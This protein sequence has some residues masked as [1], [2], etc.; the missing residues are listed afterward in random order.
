MENLLASTEIGTIFLDRDLCIRKF[1]PQIAEQFHLLPQDIGRSINSF[2]HTIVHP[3]LLEDLAHVLSSGQRR[4]VEVQDRQGR[5][6]YLRI[7]PYRVK[8]RMEGVVL[9]LIDI[10]TIKQVQAELAQAVR[11]RDQFLAMLSHELRNPLGAILNAAN[12]LERCPN[13]GAL[14]TELGDIICRQSQHMARLLDDLLDVSR[15]T[16]NKIEMR[17][18]PVAISTIIQGAVEAVRP[19]IEQNKLTFHQQSSPVDLAVLGDPVRLQQAVSNLLMNSAKYTPSGG[20]IRLETMD[21]NGQVVIRVTDNGTGISTEQIRSIFDL[22]VQ[23]DETLHRS[24]GGMGVGLTLVRAIVEQ[25]NGTVTAA[26]DGPGHGS[27]FEIRLPRLLEVPQ[28]AA[29]RTAKGELASAGGTIVIVEDQDDNRIMLR[30]LLELDGYQVF[31]AEN[32]PKGLAAIEQHRPEIALIDIGLPGL[33]GYQVAKQVRENLGNRSVY[34]VALSGYGQPQDVQ[35]ALTAGFDTHLVKPLEP[36]RLRNLLT[37][38][39]S[40]TGASQ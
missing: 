32:G 35:A 20:E 40:Q 8:T 10:S 38:R 15:V 1:T 34:L 6:Q 27:C 16:Q 3:Q 12:I 7:L 22:F 37:A 21:E 17:K 33:D 18:Q 23:S 36:Q 11:R 13:D 30:K 28:A 26:S 39:A 24:K 14:V 19:E 31:A 9:T 2:A 25:H 5:W 4:E 29:D